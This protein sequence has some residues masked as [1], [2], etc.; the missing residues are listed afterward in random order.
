MKPRPTSPPNEGSVAAVCPIGMLDTGDSPLLS[1]AV[2]LNGSDPLEDIRIRAE[3]VS[4]VLQEIVDRRT[5]RRHW[6]INE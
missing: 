6:G 2:E 3:T 5:T 4:K 1:C